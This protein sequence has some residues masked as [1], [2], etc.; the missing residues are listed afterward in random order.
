MVRL[1][2][3]I[4]TNA[5][6]VSRQKIAVSGKVFYTEKRRRIDLKKPIRDLIGMTL[7]P[8]SYK[9]ELCLSKESIQSRIRQLIDA[10]VM[11]ILFYFEEEDNNE[12][13]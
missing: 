3:L 6:Q 12:M 1:P 11:P 9:M 10:N 8:V 7:N 13:S 5:I 2:T 4:M